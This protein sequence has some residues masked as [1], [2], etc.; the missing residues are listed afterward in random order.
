M[1]WAEEHDLHY[2]LFPRSKGNE[3][4]KSQDMTLKIEIEHEPEL[5]FKQLEGLT[6]PHKPQLLE[7]EVVKYLEQLRQENG[8]MIDVMKPRQRRLRIP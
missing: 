8:R 7:D 6:V 3:L 2:L 5:E 4:G 1:K